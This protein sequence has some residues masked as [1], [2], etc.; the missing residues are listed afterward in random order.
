MGER[1]KLLALSRSHD[2]ERRLA[3]EVGKLI[4]VWQLVV[5]RDGDNG[6][7]VQ[8]RELERALRGQPAFAPVGLV[9]VFDRRR[10]VALGADLDLDEGV[11]G[12]ADV[13]AEER[14]RADDL[15]VEFGV[16]GHFFERKK[17]KIL[18]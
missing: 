7:H 4:A 9:C 15:D 5:D 6:R 3:N 2:C 16:D 1:D 10:R 11:G 18:R 14:I 8:G 17:E 12:S 13:E